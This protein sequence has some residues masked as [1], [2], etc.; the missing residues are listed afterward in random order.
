[1]AELVKSSRVAPGRS[2]AAT[3]RLL[4]AM[5]AVVCAVWLG[6]AVW[7]VPDSAGHGSHTQLGMPP[8]GWVIAFDKPCPTCGM[9]TAFAHA[10]RG[11]LWTAFATQPFAAL[12]AVAV[13]ATFWMG[14][15]S[16]ATGSRAFAMLGRLLLPRYV[17]VGVALL[18]AA[19]VYKLVVWDPGDGGVLLP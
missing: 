2:E 3:N 8:C 5:A 14:L 6:V 10:A 15:H 16:A 17:W 19:W 13:A 7:V 11:R 4:G 1:M 9:T 12:L 18:M